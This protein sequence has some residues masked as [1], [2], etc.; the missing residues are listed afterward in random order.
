MI[1][2]GND[3]PTV[4]GEAIAV[5]AKRFKLPKLTAKALLLPDAPAE[6]SV[7][8]RTAFEAKLAILTFWVQMP[9]TKPATLPGETVNAVAPSTADNV[10]AP[11]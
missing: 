9:D 4:C 7:I 3:W 5:T 1:V 10:G 11:E 6:T 8:V 2:I